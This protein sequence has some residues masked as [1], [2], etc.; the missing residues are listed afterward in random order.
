MTAYRTTFTMKDWEKTPK[1]LAIKGTKGNKK[2]R[3]KDIWDAYLM[4][5]CEMNDD[6]IIFLWKYR[7]KKAIRYCRII[8]GE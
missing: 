3:L 2:A 4:N 5:K 7:I 6:V 1:Y 8:R